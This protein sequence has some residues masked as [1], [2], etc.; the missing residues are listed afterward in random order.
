VFH[1]VSL[2]VPEV[3]VLNQFLIM[4]P[5]AVSFF[6]FLSG[7][8]LMVSYSKK[9][10]GYLKG[11]LRNRFTKVL[12]QFLIAALGYEIY[13]S[14]QEGH[15][16]LASFAAIAHGGTVLP[17]SWFVITIIVYYLFFYAVARM[18]RSEV[19]IVAGLWLTSAIY[20]VLL[21]MLGWGGYWYNTVCVFNVGTTYALL[22]NRIKDRIEV[23]SAVLTW[24]TVV[25][26]LLIIG[27]NLFSIMLP[28]C[29][30]LPL[31]L[32]LAVY[33]MG[34]YKSRILVFLG[35]ISYEIYIMQCIWRHTMYVTASLHWSIYLVSTLAMT[36]VT[37][38]LL[39]RF[40][41][42]FF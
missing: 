14:M 33:A 2:N 17:D 28:V 39:H 3:P 18:V 1:H 27:C 15:S 24:S 7:Y 13:Q 29:Y 20:I 10:E 6:F 5:L 37:A 9:G 22:E 23:H 16:T 38:W 19:G 31:L 12:P 30:L 11:F 32:V 4:G 8:G 21:Y 41:R 26:A 34:T 35:T 36:I 42:K 25:I 40:C